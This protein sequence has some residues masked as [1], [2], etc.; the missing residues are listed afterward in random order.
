MAYIVI[1]PHSKDIS[2]FNPT[3]IKRRNIEKE[4]VKLGVGMILISDYHGD[5]EVE[6]AVEA[7]ISD[8]DR[9]AVNSTIGRLF[10]ARKRGE[11][12]KLIK[13]SRPA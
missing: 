8:L 12:R 7:N 1:V 10:D 9:K 13:A 2:I 11:I 5:S 3:N 6:L 4:C